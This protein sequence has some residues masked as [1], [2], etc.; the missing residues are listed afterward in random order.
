MVRP[1]Y[2]LKML[3]IPWYRT[4]D[5]L[6]RTLIGTLAGISERQR[7]E[8]PGKFVGLKGPDRGTDACLPSVLP[9][10]KYSVRLVRMTIKHQPQWPSAS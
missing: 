9:N 1:V 7:S 10:R 6:S 4:L 5:R 2:D 8:A 3:W